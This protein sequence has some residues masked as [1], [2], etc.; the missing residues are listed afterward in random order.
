MAT[1][2]EEYK[3]KKAF[4]DFILPYIGRRLEDPDWVYGIYF[5]TKPESFIEALVSVLLRAL[6]VRDDERQLLKHLFDSCEA[7]AIEEAS[8][9]DLQKIILSDPTLKQDKS[10][11]TNPEDYIAPLVN[12]KGYH[13]LQTYR[14]ANTIL[15]KD[16]KEKAAYLHGLI[17]RR[18]SLDLHPQSRIGKAVFFDH[19]TNIT[20]GQTARIGDD[21]TFLHDVTLGAKDDQV[22]G[23]RHPI[24][25]KGVYIGAGAKLVGRIWIGDNT[26]I[27]ANAVVARNCEDGVVLA[28]VPAKVR[29]KV[30]AVAPDKLYQITHGF[31]YSQDGDLGDPNATDGYIT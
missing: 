19:A 28:G 31:R 8:I 30:G 1:R 17:A 11:T 4:S 29:G 22:T 16:S 2:P 9:Y 25:G 15:E 18:F 24:V 20:I 3:S 12:F 14:F 7:K 27:G 26:V 13:A 5:D 10:I 23:D 6:A 21:C